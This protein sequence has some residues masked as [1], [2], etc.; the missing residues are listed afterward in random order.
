MD[1]YRLRRYKQS[2]TVRWIPLSDEELLLRSQI[3]G[4]GCAWQSSIISENTGS[5]PS[6]IVPKPS[7]PTTSLFRNTYRGIQ[8][9]ISIVKV[10]LRN[11]KSDWMDIRLRLPE[12]RV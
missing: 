1:V 3:F 12:S 10:Q 6:I 2:H 7:G 9:I 8:C 11:I 5:N 4:R